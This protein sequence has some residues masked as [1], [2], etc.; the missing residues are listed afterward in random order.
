MSNF[1]LSTLKQEGVSIEQGAPH[2]PQTNGVAER[3]NSSLLSKMRCLLNQSNIP[4]SYWD[5]AAAHASLMLN[6][7]PH[8][9]GA[10]VNLKNKS[11]DSKITGGSSTLR[12][13]T[14]ERYSDSMKFLNINN[15]R[16][17]VSRDYIP[18]IN[19]KPGKVCKTTQSLPSETMQLIL[20]KPKLTNVTS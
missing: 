16:I 10:K 12:A 14:F 4:V 5:Q 6:N 15:G 18:S 13:L 1:F 3:F 7:T 20:P 11:P 17:R 9:F 19:D 8:C 2:S